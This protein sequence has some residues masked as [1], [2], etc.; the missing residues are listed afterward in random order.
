M[1]NVNYIIL[2]VAVFLVT[3]CELVDSPDET[4]FVS[5]GFITY[6]A[7]ALEGSALVTISV[8]E[9]FE[10]PG[11]LATLGQDDITDQTVVSGAVDNSTPGVYI[12]DYNISIVNEIDEPANVTQRRYVAVVSE[13]G[14]E[15]N[16]AGSYA[17]DGSAAVPTWTQ[18]AIVTGAGGAWY[19]IDKGL[20]SGNN[21][22]LF[23]AVV[24]GLNESTNLVVP[25]QNT[26]F[27][28]VNTTNVGTNGQLN[29]DGFQWTLFVSCCGNFGPI[30]Y[31]K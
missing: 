29:D 22:G 20:A 5:Q 12:L 6:P 10:D 15:V 13:D 11:F 18:G 25:D 3:S 28:T 2:F 23:F 14:K 26:R 1:K 21:L 24:G 7:L 17:G 27:G 19:N 8:G 30:I 4:A 9:T 16:L 31:S